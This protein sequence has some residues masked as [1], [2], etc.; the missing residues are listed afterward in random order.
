MVCTGYDLKSLEGLLGTAVGVG[1]ILPVVYQMLVERAVKLL[2]LSKTLLKELEEQ[3]DRFA[4]RD[5]GAMR[6]DFQSKLQRI[7]KASDAFI[8]I[9]S[10]SSLISFTLILVSAFVGACL[11]ASHMLIIALIVSVP[12]LCCGGLFLFWWDSS[13]PLVSRCQHYYDQ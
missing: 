5:L 3:D 6:I 9:S 1:F 2:S 10:I 11:T 8:L 13:R 7:E 4:I 12:V